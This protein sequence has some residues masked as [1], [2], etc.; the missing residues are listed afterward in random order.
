MSKIDKRKKKQAGGTFVGVILGLIVGLAIAVVV[1][2]MITKTPTPFTNKAPKVEKPSDIIT[3]PEQLSDPNKPLYGNRG[4]ASTPA[5]AVAPVVVPDRPVSPVVV[6]PA[7]PDLIGQKI[8]EKQHEAAKAPIIDK[9]T[10]DKTKKVASDIA[11][12]KTDSADDHWIYYLQIGAFREQAEAESA[13]AR[14]ALQGFEAKVSE[15]PSDN[16]SLYRVRIGS[17]SSLETMNRMRS[18]LSDSGISTAV[19]RSAK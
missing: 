18:K 4:Q 14:L 13:R 1:A 12:A 6:A 15:R 11:T 3:A 17:F 19:V 5:T 10:A 8:Q 9:S 2:I 7:A 16:G